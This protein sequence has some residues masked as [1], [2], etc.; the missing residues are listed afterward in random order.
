MGIG[1]KDVAKEA[2]VSTATVSH[3]INGTR[4]VSDETKKRVLDCINRLGYIPNST[5][6]SFKTGKKNTIGII[7]P[8]ILN[9]VLAMIVEE[10]DGELDKYGYKLIISTTKDIPEREQESL[11]VL[12]SGLVDGIILASTQ[13]SGKEISSCLPSNFPL[14]LIDRDV[15]DSSYDSILPN[16]NLAIAEGIHHLIETGHT[17]IGFISGLMR[18]T[19]SLY[20]KEAYCEALQNNNIAINNSLIK[21]GGSGREG[22]ISMVKELLDDKCDA[23]FISNNV[24]L[25]DVLFYLQSQN[26]ILGKDIAILGQSV[27]GYR[28]YYY[29]N[30]LGLIVQP[31]KEIG[32][33]AVKQ[34]LVRI[35]NPKSPIHHYTFNSSL[36]YK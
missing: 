25:D 26:I 32:R 15:D 21:Y 34:I 20:R 23:I 18:L 17:N 12:S 27:A 24:M 35:E 5:A 1:I 13:S 14:V 8:D 22:V 9:P 29:S 30:N 10:V 6:R 36:I 7:V 16:D 31:S 19:T 11:R 28:S 3:V 4:Y 33:S 2:N